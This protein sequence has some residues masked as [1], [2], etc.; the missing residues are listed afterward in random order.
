MIDWNDPKSN[1]TDH[2]TVGELCM[3][4]AWGRLATEADGIDKNKIIQLA[5]KA[6]D[7]RG[8]LGSPMSVHCGFRSVPYNKSQGILANDVHSKSIALDFD[9]LPHLSD[10]E[11]Q[12]RLLP[13]LEALGIR[14]EQNT[15]GWTH[16]DLHSPGPSGRHFIP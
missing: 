9:C 10:A 13:M 15:S 8:F 12:N 6:E 4:H 7:V 2:F 1:I 11:V 14:M 16:I 3:L 5:Q